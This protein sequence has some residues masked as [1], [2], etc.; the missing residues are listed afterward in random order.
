VPGRDHQHRDGD[1]R[2]DQ[3]D[4]PPADVVDDPAAE[5]GPDRGRDAPQ[6]GPLADHV[7]AVRL[8]E[9]A[10]DH[11]QAAR[12]QQGRTDSLDQPR[13]DELPGALGDPAEHRGHGEPGDPHHEHPPPPEVVTQ[14]PADQDQAGE[15]QQ[16]GV[17]HPLELG[18]RGVQVRADVAQCDVDHRAVE[19]RHPRPEHRGR[20][21]PP[22]LR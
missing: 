22:A 4:P 18:D 1:G 10:L 7:A 17:G 9:R 2:V 16:V 21:H 11:R 5:Q 12:G 13:H 15:R 14:R 6:T 8:A 19:H 20:E 3:E